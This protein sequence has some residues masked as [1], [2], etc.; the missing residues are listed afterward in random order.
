VATFASSLSE[1]AGSVSDSNYFKLRFGSLGALLFEE[2]SLFTG[3][4]KVLLS[5][6]YR[7]HGRSILSNFSLMLIS[8]SM[9]IAPS[10][11]LNGSY[12]TISR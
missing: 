4:L 8:G 3:A 1:A 9:R 7:L 6:V 12:L 5:L 11:S 2:G 10:P